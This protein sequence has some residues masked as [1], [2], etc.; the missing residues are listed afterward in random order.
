MSSPCSSSFCDFLFFSGFQDRA[1]LLV[2][3]NMYIEA[4][5]HFQDNKIV[6]YKTV[7]LGGHM[8]LHQTLFV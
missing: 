1:T 2:S 4:D 8:Y 7:W 3:F 6:S 5:F